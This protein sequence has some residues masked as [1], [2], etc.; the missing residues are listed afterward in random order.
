MVIVLFG[1]GIQC[2]AE[3]ARTSTSSSWVRVETLGQIS[4]AM[5]CS[6]I[7]L[8]SSRFSHLNWIFLICLR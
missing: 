6:L 3:K 7:M 5:F 8:I 4:L 2:E 1:S